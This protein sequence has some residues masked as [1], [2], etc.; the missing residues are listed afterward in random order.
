MNTQ[1]TTGM[2]RLLFAGMWMQKAKLSGA[3]YTIL[4]SGDME[5]LYRKFGS[6]LCWIRLPYSRQWDWELAV[7]WV[8]LSYTRPGD[9][10]LDMLAG[11]VYVTSIIK[12]I[13]QYSIHC[14][15]SLCMT[16]EVDTVITL[17]GHWSFQPG[18]DPWPLPR[19]Q[20]RV[21]ENDIRHCVPPVVWGRDYSACTRWS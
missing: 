13:H 10:N 6:L 17:L 5:F 3:R 15:S 7:W 19:S 1:G 11:G 14:M 12:E 2:Q 18:V 16:N 9:N 8:Q 20:T 21:S 4:M